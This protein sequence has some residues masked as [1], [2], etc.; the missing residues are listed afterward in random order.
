ML[1]NKKYK[2]IY[3]ERERPSLFD[4]EADPEELNDLA[5]DPA[6]AEVVKNFE[7]QL[8]EILDPIAVA[9]AARKQ[10]G[11]ITKDGKDLMFDGSDASQKK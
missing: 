3:Y 5:L 10:Q 9:K 1:V 7:A 2:Y 11:L 8:N 6:Y 4:M